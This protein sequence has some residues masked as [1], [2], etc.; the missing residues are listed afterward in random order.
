MLR[1]TDYCFSLPETHPVRLNFFFF[2]AE[3][4]QQWKNVNVPLETQDVHTMDFFI[5]AVVELMDHHKQMLS[6]VEHQLKKE[7]NQDESGKT[8]ALTLGA[9]QASWYSG[10]SK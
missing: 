7:S 3:A 4:L 10:G 9:K 2:F 6:A 5:T 1:L 8:G